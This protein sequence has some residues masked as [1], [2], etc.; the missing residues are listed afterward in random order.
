MIASSSITS[1]AM[2]DLSVR[3][4]SGFTSFRASPRKA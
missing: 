3:A 2:V 1:A 4:G